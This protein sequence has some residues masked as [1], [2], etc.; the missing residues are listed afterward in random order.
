MELEDVKIKALKSPKSPEISEQEK[1]KEHEC[2]ICLEP[3]KKK[4]IQA[5]ECM[6]GLQVFLYTNVYSMFF[7]RNVSA[8][9]SIRTKSALPAGGRLARM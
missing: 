5:L 4:K 2:V 7:I 6:V 8:V 3:L 1:K 9:G